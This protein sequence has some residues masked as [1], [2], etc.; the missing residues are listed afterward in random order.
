MN[1]GAYFNIISALLTGEHAIQPS[2][3]TGVIFKNNQ[4]EQFVRLDSE[5]FSLSVDPSD[6]IIFIIHGWMESRSVAWY[7]EL[8]DALL[9]QNEKNVVV[10]VD[11]S[12][13]SKMQRDAAVKNNKPT[14][15]IIGTFISN[16]M[17][18]NQLLHSQI[19]LIG[20][21][22]GGQVS[23]FAGKTVQ[24]LTNE[25]I[26]R[27]TAL[28]PSGRSYN[29]KPPDQRL[30]PEDAEVVAV[31]HTDTVHIGFHDSC[32]TVDLF[33][34]GRVYPQPGCPDEID[35]I[36][37]MYCSHFRAYRY[38]IEAVNKNRLIG[39]KCESYQKYEQGQC[40]GNET[41]D[42]VGAI[43]PEVRGVYYVKTRPKPPFFE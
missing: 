25:K 39:T 33:V 24:S 14:G 2:D 19:H 6:T 8:T 3:V 42:F 37:L 10:Q 4:P 29:E 31:I 16:L 34:N 38:L 40:S 30:N 43:S 13:G 32:G 36:E 11:W 22:M 41:L 35:L 5:N 7:K 18:N 21:S 15:E 26:G 9:K 23:G 12:K 17:K 27:I 28:D 1:I 20:F